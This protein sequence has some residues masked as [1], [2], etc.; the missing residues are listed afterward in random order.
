MKFKKY[1]VLAFFYGGLWG[2]LMSILER[3]EIIS[4]LEWGAIWFFGIVMVGIG[5]CYF[6]EK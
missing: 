4:K 3:A 6:S 1:A 2:W 5:C